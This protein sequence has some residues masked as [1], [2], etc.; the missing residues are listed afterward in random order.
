MRSLVTVFIILISASALFAQLTQVKLNNWKHEGLPSS[1]NWTISS[2]CTSVTQSKNDVPTFFVSPDTFEN[3]TIRGSFSVSG[4]DDDYI[5]FVFGYLRPD[6]A[7]RFFD[8]YLLDWKGVTQAGAQEGFTLSKVKGLVEVPSGTNTTH[9]YW[10]HMDT[11]QTVLGTLYGDNGWVAKKEYKFELI[12]ET[13]RVRISIDST[14]IFDVSGKFRPGRFG[15]YNYSQP[16]VTYRGFR[17]NEAPIAVDDY[18]I[19]PEDSQIAMHLTWNDTDADGHNI[20]ITG[21]DEAVHGMVNFVTGDSLVYYKPDSNFNGADSFYY[22]IT[23]GNGGIDSAKVVITVTPVNDAPIRV[24]SI[25]DA[26]IT[27]NSTNVFHAVLNDYFSDVD[28][29]DAFLDD[30]NV[31]SNGDVTTNISSDSLYLS[32]SNFTGFDTLVISV[33]DDS[34]MVARDTFVVEVV[35]ITTLEDLYIPKKFAL[36]QN[37]PNP[38]NPT[39]MISYQLPISSD[40]ELSVYNLLGQK[41]AM[42]VDKK[43][44][45]GNYQ[46]QWHASGFTSGIYIYTLE[47]DKG[48]KQSRKLV[49]LK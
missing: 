10:D 20:T 19:T 5:G 45:A 48:F 32:S 15:F 3:V 1:G 24:A 34:G 43:Q 17:L 14:Q 44:P 27:Q 38:F 18:F 40:V 8:F 30:F 29:N 4:G 46:I 9:P 41:V 11:T 2:D 39:T 23:D 28:A 47:T 33:A 25:P 21:V 36:Q 49:L 16:G 35:E 7:E 13:N 26:S 22:H 6:S 31:I 37:Y 12:Y 42:L